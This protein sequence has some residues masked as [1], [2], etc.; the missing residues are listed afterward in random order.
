M[1]ATSPLFDERPA[2]PRVCHQALKQ[3]SFSLFLSLLAIVSLSVTIF[4]A[5]NYSL[6][7]PLSSK[8]VFQNPGRSILLLNLL[9]QISTFCLAELASCVLSILRWAFAG[10]RPSGT[11]AYTFLAL[12]SATNLAGVLHL[13][14]GKGP[15][16]GRLQWDGHRVWGIQR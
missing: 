9:S 3:R 1:E 7:Q 10:S 8:L 6:P 4:F 5:Y 12:S 13:L 11:P 15:K 14:P 2:Q 16:P